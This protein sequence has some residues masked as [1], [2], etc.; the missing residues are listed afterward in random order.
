LDTSANVQD[1][2]WNAGRVS[3]PAVIKDH[4]FVCDQ[5]GEC[6]VLEYLQ[7]EL[8]VHSG[9]GLRYPALANTAYQNC[10]SRLDRR[11]AVGGSPEAILR[12]HS[13]GSFQ[14]FAR[15]A[16]LSSR[17][18]KGSDELAYAFASLDNVADSG[19][20]WN[21][22][23]SL[24]ERT[25]YI[26]TAAAPK[27]KSID[28]KRFDPRC[29]L[30]ALMLDINSP[31]SGDVSSQFHPYSFKENAKSVAQFK[32]PIPPGMRAVIDRFPDTHTFCLE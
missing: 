32:P 19:T 12:G 5:T 18:S 10:M 29:S 28:L 20:F 25:A 16:L 17:Y 21:I 22:V 3:I 6:A 27:V 8:V 24:K 13:D 14:R 23:F 4:Y 26:K 15:A 2:I 9:A 31:S 1:A 11:L 7:G 30:P